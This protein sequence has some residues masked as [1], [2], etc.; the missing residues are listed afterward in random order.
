MSESVVRSRPA[1]VAALGVLA[2]LVVQEVFTSVVNAVVA[3]SALSSRSPDGVYDVNQAEYV[4]LIF[5][6][7]GSYLATSVLPFALGVYFS[8]WIVA[9]IAAGLTLR[10]VV[11][12]SIV[13]A[14]VGAALVAVVRVIAGAVRGI[15][16]MTSVF[17]QAFPWSTI[18]IAE[19]QFQAGSILTGALFQLLEIAPLV[20]LAGVLLW[21]WMRD[22]DGGRSRA[23]Q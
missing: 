5:A 8:L 11:I 14:S 17:G 4:V 7:L 18:D 2:V 16:N 9:P 19:L 1:L 6:Q 13:A 20:V 23:S 10:L 15:E 22:T 21:L 3:S 12:R